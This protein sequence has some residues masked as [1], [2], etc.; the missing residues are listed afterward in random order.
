MFQD[1]TALTGLWL[2]SNQLTEI[3]VDM[4]STLSSLTSFGSCWSDLNESGTLFVLVQR[5]DC[6]ES[7]IDT[8]RWNRRLKIT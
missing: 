6:H 5:F 7:N 2:R 8:F 4:F 1:L 3:P